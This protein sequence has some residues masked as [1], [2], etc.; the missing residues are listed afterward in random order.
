[1]QWQIPPSLKIKINLNQ[2][3]DQ[4]MLLTVVKST[5]TENK[6]NHIVKL[7]TKMETKIGPLTVGRQQTYYVASS[8]PA[9]VGEEINLDLNLFDVEERDF[10]IKEGENAGEVLKL[11]WLN[12]KLN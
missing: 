10:K 3:E 5:E 8:T 1:L 9:T 2:L 11:K 6:L 4:N 12:L 7:Q